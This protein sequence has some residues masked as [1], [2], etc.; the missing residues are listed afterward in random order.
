MTIEINNNLLE[1]L[2]ARAE[3]SERKHMNYDLRT[4][5]DDGGQRMLNALMLETVVPIHRHPMSTRQ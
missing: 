2:L 1:E 5:P 3:T 4:T